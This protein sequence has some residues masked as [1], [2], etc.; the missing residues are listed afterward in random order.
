MSNPN[1]DG[2]FM[3]AQNGLRAAWKAAMQKRDQEHAADGDSMAA[4]HAD[5]VVA[6]L[7]GY[8][9]GVAEMAGKCIYNKLEG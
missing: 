7:Q 3:I 1:I 4:S 2:K 8:C 6:Y 5:A 9:D